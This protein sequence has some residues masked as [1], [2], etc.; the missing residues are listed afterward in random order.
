MDIQAE[1][2]SVSEELRPVEALPDNQ[3]NA[4]DEDLVPQPAAE[5]DVET[6]HSQQ[7]V[8]TFKPISIKQQ[9]A[10][11][12]RLEQSHSFTE[13]FEKQGI[14]SLHLKCMLEDTSLRLED[15]ICGIFVR[16][17]R[18]LQTTLY[19][20]CWLL[21]CFRRPEMQSVCCLLCRGSVFR[22]CPYKVS[23][24]LR[25]WSVCLASVMPS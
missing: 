2:L 4:L 17:E 7:E 18:K 14:T 3:Q 6:E 25:L 23:V 1:L 15:Y 24:F 10:A 12:E 16:P 9:H 22:E 8:R 21:W 11:P 19:L 5:A 13:V 20:S